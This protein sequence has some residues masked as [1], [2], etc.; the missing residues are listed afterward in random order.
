[1]KKAAA[2]LAVGGITL[3]VISADAMRHALA[4]MGEIARAALED[5]IS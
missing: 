5:G 4:G 3:D 2:L 1:L